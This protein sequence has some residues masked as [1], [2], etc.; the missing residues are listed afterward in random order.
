MGRGRVPGF[1]AAFAPPLARVAVVAPDPLASGVFVS[2]PPEEA[3]N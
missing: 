2:E 1:H 3:S